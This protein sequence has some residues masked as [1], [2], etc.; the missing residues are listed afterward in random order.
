MSS[1]R[2]RIAAFLQLAKEELD[3]AGWLVERAPRQC[4]Y[5]VQQAAEK[6]ARAIL[7]AA[8]VK[9]GT[10]HNLG[11]M[12]E[13]LPKGHPWVEKIKPLDRHSPAATRYRYPTMAGR[14][15]DPPTTRALQRDVAELADLL[16]EARR[17]LNEEAS[18]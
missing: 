11:Q 8:D 13:A 7:T 17:F 2:E 10:G 4:A 14:L 16:E 6:L 9:F 3:V 5:L 12:A 18:L 15:V 1:Q